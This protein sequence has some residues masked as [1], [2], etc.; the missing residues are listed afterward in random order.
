MDRTSASVA[1]PLARR[2]SERSRFRF[3]RPHSLRGDVSLLGSELCVMV[4]PHHFR[5]HPEEAGSFSI[6]S[7]FRFFFADFYA[8]MN[9]EMKATMIRIEG[10]P[11]VATRLADA[12]GSEIR[13]AHNKRRRTS[14]IDAGGEGRLAIHRK[15]KLA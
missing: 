12:R 1:N 15:K 11:V 5:D 7:N 3:G 8:C 14:K 6:E 2:V 13:L 9:R 10:I 4:E